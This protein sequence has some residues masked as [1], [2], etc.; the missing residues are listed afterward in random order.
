MKDKIK[1][2]LK[3]EAPLIEWGIVFGLGFEKDDSGMIGVPA[4]YITGTLKSDLSAW[5]SCMVPVYDILD[6]DGNIK[7]KDFYP[8]IDLTGEGPVESLGVH[9]A[10]WIDSIL[11]A[12]A[13]ELGVDFNR[14]DDWGT[15]EA[16]L[17]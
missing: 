9:R 5:S 15:I 10:E 17:G 11:L 16:N 4:F 6:S 7:T 14:G 13:N 3:K 8:I 12:I 2:I 1:A